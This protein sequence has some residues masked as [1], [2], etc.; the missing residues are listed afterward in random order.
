MKRAVVSTG[1][2]DADIRPAPLLSE[3]KRL[4]IEG[5]REYFGDA[6]ALVEVNCPACDA[7]EAGAA[8]EKQGFQYA[9]CG[10]CESV[11]VSPR[12]SREALNRYYQTS[13]ASHYRVEHFSRETA[14]ARRRHLLR[15]HAQ[16]MS[17]LFDEMHAPTPA[18]H[19]DIGSN[20]PVLFEELKA[21]G[22]FESVSSLWPLPGLEAEFATIGVRSAADDANGYSVVTAFEQVEHHYSPFELAREA[23]ARLAPGG[24]LFFTTRSSSG[25]D[26]Q[27]LGGRA[28][29]I[30]VPEHLNL[31]SIE[32]LEQLIERAGF[33]LVELSTPGQLDVELVLRTMAEDESIELPAFA[34][35]LLRH[36]GAEAHADLQ[37]YLQ[38]HRLSSHVRIAAQKPNV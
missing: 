23:Y 1:L 38:K 30:F 29:Y 36:R 15:S 17:R 10:S 37:E 22:L 9:R 27:V 7:A 21:V 6:S 33:R 24:L 12:P 13:A 20:S 5:A 19:L 11:Y 35:Y 31:L 26:L 3:F 28:P 32:G 18:N 8:F 2:H 34:D 16:W 25:F 4:S 14:E